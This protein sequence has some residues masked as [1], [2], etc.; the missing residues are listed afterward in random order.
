MCKFPEVK[1]AGPDSLIL[2][3]GRV[4]CSGIVHPHRPGP[5]SGRVSGRFGEFELGHPRVVREPGLLLGLGEVVDGAPLHT[6]PLPL[7]SSLRSSATALPRSAKCGHGGPEVVPTQPIRA[8]ATALTT[9]GSAS[10]PRASDAVRPGGPGERLAGEGQPG[11]GLLPPEAW[12]YLGG[13]GRPYHR[14]RRGGP[15]SAR[16][17]TPSVGPRYTNPTPTHPMPGRVATYRTHPL[18]RVMGLNKGHRDSSR[19]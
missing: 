16:P 10:H 13:Q 2:P 7:A 19:H 14:H 17:L 1:R 8:L 6:D 9:P 3:E 4:L 15:R 5:L 11:P 18:E 12:C